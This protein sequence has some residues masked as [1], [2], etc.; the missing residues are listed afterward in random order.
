ML[1]VFVSKA[2]GEGA[3]LEYWEAAAH[4]VDICGGDRVEADDAYRA[5]CDGETV[6]IGEFDIHTEDD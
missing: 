6:A 4:L 2:G 1:F 3:M 5:L